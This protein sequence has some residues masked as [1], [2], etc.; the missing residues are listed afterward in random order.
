MGGPQ[1]LDHETGQIKCIQSDEKVSAGSG[2]TFECQVE[3]STPKSQ[4]DSCD[5]DKSGG[6]VLK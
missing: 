2:E 3:T 6:N 1:W 4:T 5:L